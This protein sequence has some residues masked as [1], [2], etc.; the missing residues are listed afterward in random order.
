MVMVGLFKT[1][2]GHASL[3][4]GPTRWVLMKSQRAIA[5]TGRIMRGY[6]PLE[7]Y[8]LYIETCN[9]CNLRCTMCERTFWS[10]QHYPKM[11]FEQFKKIL[12]QFHHLSALSLTGI[13]EALLN[14]DIIRMISYAKSKGI[15]VSLTT[16]GTLLNPLMSHRIINSGLDELSFSMESA[17][18]D[19]YEKIRVGSNFDRVVENIRIFMLAKRNLGN[20]T[21]E[22]VMRTVVMKHTIQEIPGLVKLVHD[23]GIKHLMVCS[24]ISVFKEG[25]EDPELQEM[26]DMRVK[27]K[28]LAKQLSVDFEWD[29]GYRGK[30]ISG[31]CLLPFFNIYIFREGYVGPCCF[32]TQRL[33]RNEIIDKY[34]FGNVLEEDFSKI[35]N[36]KKFRGFRRKLVS[37]NY[38][39]LPDICKDC[40]KINGGTN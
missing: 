24:V 14:K 32:V 23:L 17:D 26:K 37:S 12:D 1:V 4:R 6:S 34:T 3:L 20:H 21:P 9:D 15:F 33:A 31:T 30:F 16:N 29:I 13:G 2:R 10:V 11:T 7:P 27:S 19:T 8:I 22:V 25:L 18:P 28:E 40:R 39:E 35:Q 38:N 5:L 36:N